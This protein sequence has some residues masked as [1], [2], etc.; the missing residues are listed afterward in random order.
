MH[1]TERNRLVSTMTV[2]R[3][4]ALGVVLKC[5]ICLALLTL[6]LVIGNAR[7]KDGVALE[8]GNGMPHSAAIAIL[9][10]AAAHRKEVF[11]DRRARYAGNATERTLAETAPV[12]SVEAYAP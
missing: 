10:S 11:D 7:E 9:P 1:S 8:A 5:G 2:K 6:L 12:A 4:R 3:A